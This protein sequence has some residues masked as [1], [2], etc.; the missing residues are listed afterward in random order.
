VSTIDLQDAGFYF[1]KLAGKRKDAAVAGCRLAAVRCVQAI[2]TTIIP[3]RD[4]APVDRGIYRAGWKTELT[5]TGAA[6]YNDSPAAAIIEFGARGEN[7]KIGRKL[8]DALTKWVKRKGIAKKTSEAKAIAWAI[9]KKAASGQ[10]FHNRKPGGGQQV[11]KECN[12]S[13]TTRYL[14]EEVIRKLEQT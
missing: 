5:T 2:V 12:A 14:R 11:M 6:F 4:P 9:A 10:G 13:F 8:I 1:E 7:I 3:S